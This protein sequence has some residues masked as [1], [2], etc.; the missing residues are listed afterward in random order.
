MENH[1]ST[2]PGSVIIHFIPGGPIDAA[3]RKAIRSHVTLDARRKQRERKLLSLQTKPSK[4]KGPCSDDNLCKCFIFESLTHGLP[5]KQAPK[6]RA[7][8]HREQ[9][10][11]SYKICPQCRCVQFWA[12]SPQGQLRIVA[13]MHP[14]IVHILQSVF[15]PLDSMPEVPNLP[16]YGSQIINDIKVFCESPFPSQCTTIAVASKKQTEL[17]PTK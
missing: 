11:D 10:A 1:L 15:D 8:L 2:N 13:K 12:L 4:P 7:A 6:S 17:H 3:A 16:P 5:L 14:T 9:I